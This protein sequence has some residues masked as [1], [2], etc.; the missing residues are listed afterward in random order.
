M[1]FDDILD[2]YRTNINMIIDEIESDYNK[3]HYEIIIF[4]LSGICENIDTPVIYR[5]F[6]NKIDEKIGLSK[7]M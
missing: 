4:D 7:L 1:S 5:Y 6:L 2:T 3:Q